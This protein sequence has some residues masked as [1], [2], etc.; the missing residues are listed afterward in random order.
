MFGPLADTQAD[1][2]I[3]VE[4]A[5]P[6]G[7]GSGMFTNGVFISPTTEHPEEA[8]IWLEFLTSSDDAAQIRLDAAWELPPVADGSKHHLP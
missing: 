1:W 4:P 2:D 5:G 8:E 6:G 3:V 7:E